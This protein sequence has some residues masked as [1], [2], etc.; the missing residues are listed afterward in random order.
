MASKVQIKYERSS[1]ESMSM[2]FR[3]GVSWLELISGLFLIEA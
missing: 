1:N 2:M 3:V